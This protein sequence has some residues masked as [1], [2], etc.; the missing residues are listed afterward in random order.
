M[1][2][3]PRRGE[4]RAGRRGES[5]APIPPGRCARRPRPDLCR[6]PNPTARASSP[7][8]G[9]PPITTDRRWSPSTPVLPG[10]GASRSATRC[11]STCLAVTST[12]RSANLR[13]IAWRTLGLNFA[14]GRQPRPAGAPRRTCT[15]PPCGVAP[16]DQAA[17]LRAVTDALPNVSGIRV[18][19]VLGAVA[20][21]AAEARRGARRPRGSL[22]LASG[23]LVLA[24]R[25]SRRG[26][27]GGSTR[28]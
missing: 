23:A 3:P 4:R 27:A 10:A 28:R 18:A 12:S 16:P 22:S 2:A 25:R 20:A 1:R 9:G 19:D 24:G 13:D 14:L 26:N 17:L 5:D 21:L 8:P 7:A 6:R 15:S 11:A